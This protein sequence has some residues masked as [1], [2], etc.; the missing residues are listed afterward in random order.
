MK[1]PE[2][3]YSILWRLKNNEQV[4]L[5]IPEHEL[6]CLNVRELANSIGI[7]ANTDIACLEAT[8]KEI[9]RIDGLRKAVARP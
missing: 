9:V 5:D 1:T 8:V 4:T 6:A 7:T 2:R 3:C